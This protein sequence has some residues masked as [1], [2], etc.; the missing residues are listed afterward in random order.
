MHIT[1]IRPSFNRGRAS[2]AMQPLAFAILYGLTPPD[3]ETHLM[4]ERV[5]D[6]DLNIETDLVAISVESFT[7]ARAYAIARHFRSRGISVLMGGYHPTFLPEEALQ[8]ADAVVVGDAEGVWQEIIKDARNNKLR[9]VY[10]T[11]SQE[12]LVGVDYNRGIFEGKKYTSVAPVQFSR[13][14]RFACDFCSIYA[15]YGRNLRQRPVKEVLQEIEALDKKLIFF[16]D[17]NILGERAKAKEL[18]EGLIPLNIKWSCQ[19]S[20]DVTKD[21][22]LLSLME[23]SGCIVA[24]TGFESLNTQN[25]VQMRKKWNIRYGDYATAIRKF[26]D[27]GMMIYGTFVFGYDHDTV[28]AFDATLEFALRQKFFIANFNPLT[29]TPGSKLYSRLKKEGRLLY[30]RW[31]LDPNFQYGKTIFQP[32]GMTPEELE[33]GCFRIRKSFNTYNSIFSRLINA[34]SNTKNLFNLALFLKA[35]LVSRREIFRKQGTNL[36]ENDQDILTTRD[37]AYHLD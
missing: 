21:K 18:F 3:I 4:D 37:H 6:I 13:G 20:I 30:D 8:F 12:S 1:F 5:E 9:P 36:V 2:D 23:K 33:E 14:C 19:I 17:D 15:F 10:T 24:L 31:W 7:A 25:L 34:K 32:K 27:H 22:E 16:V 11:N 26:Y 35:N 29:P 28:D